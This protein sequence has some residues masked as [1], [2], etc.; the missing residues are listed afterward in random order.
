MAILYKNNIGFKPKS[1]LHKA[2]LIISGIFMS[3]FF[4]YEMYNVITNYT[5]LK[6]LLKLVQPI[7]FAIIW[8]SQFK[9]VFYT[10]IENVIITD[11]YVE[12]SL[13]NPINVE[14]F[15]WSNIKAINIQKNELIFIDKSGKIKQ[16][17]L[18]VL[19]YKNVQNLKEVLKSESANNDIEI[20]I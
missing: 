6:A 2:F 20:S 17:P 7:F 5:G 8:C 3:L 11:Q 19:D 12:W 10:K 14:N 13:S 9:D 15:K 4:C 16:F 1:K 18:G